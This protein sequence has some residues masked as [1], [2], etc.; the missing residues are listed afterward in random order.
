MHTVEGMFAVRV[1][2]DKFEKVRP[3]RKCEV[4]LKAFLDGLFLGCRVFGAVAVI[5]V[6]VLDNYSQILSYNPPMF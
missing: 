2:V 6:D 5:R 4:V 1:I 3:T